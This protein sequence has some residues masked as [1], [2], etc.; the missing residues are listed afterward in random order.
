MS[1]H[2]IDVKYKSFSVTLILIEFK[3]LAKYKKD[4]TMYIYYIFIYLNIF[5]AIV[6]IIGMASAWLH[7]IFS[8]AP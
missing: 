3:K 2:G 1:H 8:P 6:V 4:N 5:L 7:I